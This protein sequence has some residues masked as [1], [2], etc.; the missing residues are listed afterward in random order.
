MAAS[1]FTDKD[2]LAIWKR[3]QNRRQRIRGAQVKFRVG[4]RVRISKVKMRFAKGSQQKFS[5]ELFE[6]SK[7]FVKVCDQSTNSKI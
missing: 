5:K 6:L 1:K 4:Q 7:S 2:I 3:M